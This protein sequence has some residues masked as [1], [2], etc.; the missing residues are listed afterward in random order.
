M[1]ETFTVTAHR[2]VGPLRFGMTRGEVRAALGAHSEEFFRT[3]DAVPA[4][5]FPS[6]PAF[7]YY[8]ETGVLLAAEF[9]QSARV[10]IDGVELTGRCVSEVIA[11]LANADFDIERDPSGCI[12]RS[13][14]V[15][16]WTE[17]GFAKPPQSVIVFAPGYYD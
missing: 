7:A 14:G 13:L 6:I 15:G 4:D 5:H 16:V 10:S 2:G 1:P 8:S 12:S 3:P 9:G 17:S 11:D